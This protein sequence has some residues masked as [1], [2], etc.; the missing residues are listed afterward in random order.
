MKRAAP[1]WRRGPERT[2][3][4]RSLACMVFELVTGDYLFDPKD[5]P[6]QH[7]S[8]DE[9]ACVSA[10]GGVA[11]VDTLPGSDHLALMVELLGDIF[12]RFTTEG[13]RS[14]DFFNKRGV[15]AGYRLAAHRCRLTVS[16]QATSGTS[17]SW[18]RGACTRC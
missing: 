10:T 16:P 15:H 7:H 9:G 6:N 11:R 5:D 2:A 14:K 12:K 8:R 18:T 1:V 13:K 3:V 4:F 17:P